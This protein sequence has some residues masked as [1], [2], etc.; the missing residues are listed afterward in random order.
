MYL[1][2]NPVMQRELLVNLRNSRSFFQLFAYVAILGAV[3]YIA[4]PKDTRLDMSNPE[5]ARRLVNLIFLEQFI[6]ASLLAPSFAAGSLTGEKERKSYEMLLAAPLKPGAVVLGKLVASLTHLGILV[7]SSLPIV[8]LCLPLGGVSFYEVLAVYWLMMIAMVLFG[9]IS[10]ACSSFFRRTSASLIVS[11]LLILPIAALMIGLWTAFG[12][13]AAGA[14]LFFS[15]F[16]APPFCLGIAALLFLKTA[17]RLLYPPDVGSEG[18]E[19]VDEV[20]EIKRAVGLVIQRDQFPDRLFAPPKRTTL[21]EE[22]ANP[23][24]DKEM[25][26]ELFSQGTLMLRV[27]I[28]ISMALM[29]ILMPFCLFFQ[30][31]NAAWYIVSVLGFNLLISPVFSA[32][33]VTGERERETLELLLVTIISPWKI[34]S[35]K[36]LAGL[37]I[38]VVLSSFLLVPVVLGV[39]L[40]P[41]HRLNIISICGYLL[42]FMLTCLTTSQVS[43][44]CSVISRKTTVALMRAYVF[45]LFIM[46]LPV[47]VNVFAQTFLDAGAVADAINLLAAISPFKA[48]FCLPFD[49]REL[50]VL[51]RPAD[52]KS[53]VVYLTFTLAVNVVLA[54]GML[55][56]FQLRWRVAS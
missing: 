41:I 34:L 30:P 26:S 46:V 5:A 40:V 29:F 45:L 31:Q 14:R 15:F 33:S 23:I 32:G 54:S 39:A 11:Y 53:F 7:F 47:A 43:M 12:S 56:A 37:R 17:N 8:I 21:L 19:V 42:V 9:M 6:V 2:E 20:Q 16:V 35:G 48:V 50:D 55:R 27:V 24:F 51:P 25:R 18:K 10:L 3:V 22:N 52:W 49:V 4:W 36:L 38:S 13:R 44:F 28:Q 1:I